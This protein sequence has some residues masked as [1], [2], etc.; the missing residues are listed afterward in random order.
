MGACGWHRT[1]TAT[2][3]KSFWTVCNA[4]GNWRLLNSVIFNQKP[5]TLPTKIQLKG[6]FM[7][8]K[9]GKNLQKWIFLFIILEISIKNSFQTFFLADW[10][11]WLDQKRQWVTLLPPFHFKNP[12]TK[13]L[14]HSL[15]AHVSHFYNHTNCSVLITRVKTGLLNIHRCKTVA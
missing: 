10:T 2:E 8:F 5:S 7:T 12:S 1:T 15:I 3:Q 6:T 9:K 14:N 11:F 4:M 13:G